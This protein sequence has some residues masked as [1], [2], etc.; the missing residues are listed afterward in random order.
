MVIGLHSTFNHSLIREG[1]LISGP[2]ADPTDH[3]TR[4]VAVAQSNRGGRNRIWNRKDE[5]G[6]KRSNITAAALT[7][8]HPW[9]RLSRMQHDEAFPSITRES[10]RR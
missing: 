2:T 8:R 10:L 5:D 4:G 1:A 7:S 9:A 6:C 3:D